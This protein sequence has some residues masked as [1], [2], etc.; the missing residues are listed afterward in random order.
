MVVCAAASSAVHV[1]TFY[2]M[3]RGGGGA[4]VGKCPECCTQ[5]R[6]SQSSTQLLEY[7]GGAGSYNMT[8]MG[9]GGGGVCEHFISV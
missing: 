8:G 9:E 3:L 2:V 4:C 7:D 1:H 5:F 6:H